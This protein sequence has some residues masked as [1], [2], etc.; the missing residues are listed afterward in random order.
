MAYPTFITDAELETA[1]Q[2][3]LKTKNQPQIPASALLMLPAC[4]IEGAKTIG[5]K[6]SVRGFTPDQIAAWDLAPEFNRHI[7]VYWLLVYAANF[8]A[9]DLWPEKHNVIDEL[10]TIAVLIDG[11]PVVPGNATADFGAGMLAQDNATYNRQTKW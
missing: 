9:D 10:D 11:V 6:L 3:H 4:N 1:L 7:G 2:A 8:S 5:A